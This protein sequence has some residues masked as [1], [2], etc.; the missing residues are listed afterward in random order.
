MIATFGDSVLWGQGLLEEH[1]F[2]RLL[3][4]SDGM[5]LRPAHSG[6]LLGEE[7]KEARKTVYSEVPASY[8]S[9][10]QQVVHFEQWADVDLAIVNGGINDVSL[11]KLLD[12]WEKPETIVA[13]TQQYCGNAMRDLLVAMGL[14]AVKPGARIAVMGYYPMLSDATRF[15]ND[16]QP[17]LLMQMHGV[18]AMSLARGV[19]TD[20]ETLKKGI[21]ANITAFWK[22]SS[23][24]MRDAVS[25]ANAT[26]GREMCLF[27]ESP[28]TEVN[29][30]WAP[31][32]QLWAM[33][34]TLEPTDEVR[35]ERKT[36]CS[37][38]FGGVLETITRIK[39]EHA[40]VGHPNVTGAARMT[41]AMQAALRNSVS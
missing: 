14:Q 7:G 4:G 19:A 20:K 1:K 6:A 22:Q 11:G 15:E 39:C 36:E 21:V 9:V 23:L 16:R 29:A 25:G 12:P 41:Q 24:S 13:L 17:K 30:L 35:L 33:T 18:Q 8:P 26:L 34:D 32:E 38:V 3:A 28:L 2:D 31:E 27:V 10:H 40:S 5:L 37:E